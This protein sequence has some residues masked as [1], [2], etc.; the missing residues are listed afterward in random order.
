[1]QV[2]QY[3]PSKQIYDELFSHTGRVRPGLGPISW[4]LNKDTVEQ[5]NSQLHRCGHCLGSFRT[6]QVFL[7]LVLGFIISVDKVNA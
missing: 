7:N 4:I 6:C 3:K 5:L 2:D 1:M